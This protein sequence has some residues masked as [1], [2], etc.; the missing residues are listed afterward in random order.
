MPNKN[1]LIGETIYIIGHKNPDA[2]SIISAYAYQVYRHSQGDFNYIAVRAG[3]LNPATKWLFEKFN[4]T[5]PPLVTDISNMK[6]ALVDH[7]D[8]SVRP[9]GWEKAT[10]VEVVDHHKLSLETAEPSKITIRPYGATA[11]LI[12]QKMTRQKIAMDENIAGL[13][14]GAIID[15]TVAFRSPTTTH[16]DQRVAGELLTMAGIGD[17]N[18]FARELFNKKDV[19]SKMKIRDIILQDYKEFK[20]GNTSLSISQVETMNNK[21][22]FENK[23]AFIK[24]LQSL[25]QETPL[26]YRVV[27][28]TDPLRNDCIMLYIGKKEELIPKIFNK[29]SEEPNTIY[30]PGVLSRKK[31]ILPVFIENASELV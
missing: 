3:D 9:N 7:T 28:L 17:I 30:L 11:T 23:E 24:D 25:N 12:A 4:L 13:I 16:M 6:V 21:K 2:D 31:Q 14:L 15:D 29:D 27:L 5:P 18:E 26:D 1:I 19:W 20:I 8:P 10:I 22:L